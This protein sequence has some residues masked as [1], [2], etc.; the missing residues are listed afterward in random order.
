MLWRGAPI[1]VRGFV[2]GE[3]RGAV[4]QIGKRSRAARRSVR[5]IRYSRVCRGLGRSF[6]FSL[7]FAVSAG[8]KVFEGGGAGGNIGTIIRKRGASQWRKKI[9]YGKRSVGN[10]RGRGG[11]GLPGRHGVGIQACLRG[12]RRIRGLS[13]RGS[14]PIGFLAGNI[15]PPG[16]VGMRGFNVFWLVAGQRRDVQRRGSVARGRGERQ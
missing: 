2:Y 9:I 16:G 8:H 13:S 7:V 10:M 12:R 5:F 11:L 3:F 15:C 1:R 4:D 6:R 14:L